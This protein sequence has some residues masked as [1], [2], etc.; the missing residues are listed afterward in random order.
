[1]VAFSRLP[2]G[3]KMVSMIFLI[4]LWYGGMGACPAAANG[5]IYSLLDLNAVPADLP[6][7]ADPS[8]AG[9]SVRFHWK[10]IEPRQ[11]EYHWELIDRSLALAQ[12]YKKQ[13]MIRVVAGVFSPEWVYQAGAVT[14]K[15][16]F[17]EQRLKRLA[18]WGQVTP[19]R[20][21]MIAQV[22]QAPVVWDP[23]YLQHWLDFVRAFGKR[24]DGNPAIFSIQM[25]GG[26][27]AAEMG[28]R[29][30]FQW[31]R[32]GYSDGRIIDTWKT[33]IDAYQASFPRTPTNLDILEPIRGQSHATQ[34]VVDYC[35]TKYP[36][37]VYLQH[38]G[39]NARGGE[40]NFR[41]ILRGAAART[42]IGYQMTGGREWNDNLVGDRK[43]AFSYGLE[44]G[45]SYVEVYHSDLADPS[46]RDTVNYLA[47][48][49]AKQRCRGQ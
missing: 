1:M 36:G 12:K 44:D 23:I 20:L 14:A 21:K 43:T 8:V 45:A 39:L 42:C 22:R 32:F 29:P 6:E 7:L 9:V 37:K 17:D 33:I 46:L 18:K 25:T 15:P 13:V 27:L 2:M 38:N 47:A 48:R 35:L 41:A 19:Q 31:E 28:L 40:A 3:L 5:G 34:Q 10:A 16:N 26:G 30:E 4:M 24:Y 11:G 49:L